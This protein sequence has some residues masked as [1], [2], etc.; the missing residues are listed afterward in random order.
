MIRKRKS[1][2]SRG[3]DH[4]S[5]TRI[6]KTTL[7]AAADTGVCSGAPVMFPVSP[8]VSAGFSARVSPFVVGAAGVSVGSGTLA[9]SLEFPVEEPF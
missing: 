3:I 8:S 5:Y 7:Q 2:M 1:L 6:G 4:V 9:A